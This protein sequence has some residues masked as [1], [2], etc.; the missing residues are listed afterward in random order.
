MRGGKSRASIVNIGWDGA[1]RGM[2]GESAQLFAAAK[3]AVEAFSR[4][5]AQTLA[6]DVR[7]NCIAPGWIRTDWGNDA[8]EYWQHRAAKESLADRWGTPEDIARVVRF[9]ASED[10][11]FISG[12]TLDVNGGFRLPG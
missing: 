6:P 3:G 2:P 11:D 9:L 5:L 12:Q 10:A 1:A 7:V 4:S 8:S